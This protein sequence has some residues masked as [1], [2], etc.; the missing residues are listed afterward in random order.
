MKVKTL[1]V[2][3]HE[4]KP[5][6]SVDFDPAT[7]LLASCGTDKE[8][9]LWRVGEDADGNPDVTHEETLT[10]HTK[11]VNCVRFSP[12]G[13]ALASGGDA[14]EVIV[15]RPAPSDKQVTNQHGDRTSW[16]TSAVLRGHSDDVQDLAWAPEGAGI[17]TGSV[18][19][20][21]IVWDVPKA[22][23]ALRLRGHTHYVQGVGWDPH[24]EYVV[25]QSGDRTARVFASRGM[26]AEQKMLSARWCKHLACQKVLKSADSVPDPKEETR[27]RVRNSDEA[28]E[29]AP[30]AADG[31]KPPRAPLFHDDTM[32]SFFRRPA[33][34]PCGSFLAVPAGVHREHAGAKEQHCTYIYARDAFHRPTLRLPG[35]APAVCVRFS[36]VFYERKGDA[37]SAKTRPRTPEKKD[38]QCFDAVDA[39]ALTGDDTA[40][41]KAH[42]V[43]DA[44]APNLGSSIDL[45]FRVLFAVCTTDTV[46]VYD[47]GSDAPV[48]F[49]GGLHYAAITDAAWSPDGYTLVVSSSDGYCSVLQFSEREIG[50]PLAPEKLPEH[51]RRLTPA[52]RVR[53]AR[54]AAAEAAR[55]A[56]AAAE[57]AAAKAKAKAEAKA[58]T[59]APA[60]APPV[61]PP[62]FAAMAAV[63]APKRVA[64]EPVRRVAPEPATGVGDCAAAAT[65]A[66]ASFAKRAA[67]DAVPADAPPAKAPKRVAPTA[68]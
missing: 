25:S 37:F 31:E 52:A 53:A 63:D 44:S 54:E 46:A 64:P 62:A 4:K 27:V 2:L 39:P 42:G 30:K 18:D 67:P 20:E 45:P 29:E 17:V 13:D 66:T 40:D 15:W 14:G 58:E 32:G 36:P 61:E 48:A 22:K 51:L 6:L 5:V 11:T 57:E 38:A 65:A 28:T 68:L 12:G 26:G 50:E 41:A 8:I 60:F 59:E 34:S 7:G 35:I 55:R 56:A 23:G 21:C 16:R 49:V 47:S 43:S 19:N 24:G 9:K 10:A 3:W 1:Q 33:W